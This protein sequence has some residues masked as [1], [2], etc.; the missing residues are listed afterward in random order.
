M[1]KGTLLL[2]DMKANISIVFNHFKD[3]CTIEHA[4][5]IRKATQLKIQKCTPISNAVNVILLKLMME[6]PLTVF[7]FT[8]HFLF[9]FVT[10]LYVLLFKS[11]SSK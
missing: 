5:N 10:F 11:K 7:S 6:H 4:S 9:G 8:N 3:I 2:I 1:W